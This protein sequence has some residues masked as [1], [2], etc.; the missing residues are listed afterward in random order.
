MSSLEWP[1]GSAPALPQLEVAY[2]EASLSSLLD[3]PRTLAVIGFGRRAPA[4]D[5]DPRYFNVGLEPLGAAVPFEVWRVDADALCG[6]DGNIAWARAGDLSFGS[7]CVDEARHGGITPAAEAAYRQL[8]DHLAS[9]PHPALLRSWNYIDAITEGEG[10]AERYRQFCIGRA[11]GIGQRLSAYPAATAIGLRDGARVLRLYW[12]AGPQPGTPIENPRQVAAWRYPRQYGPQPPSF[13]RATLPGAPSLPL[14][15]SGT[16]S[17]VGHASLHR[18]SLADQVDETFRNFASL[19]Q[20]ARGLRPSLAPAF[21]AGSLL[22]AYVRDADSAAAVAA[23]LDR[24]LPAATQRLLLAAD[25]CRAEL[26]IEIDGF[27]R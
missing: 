16:A 9:G 19:L 11:L 10:D 13:S 6:R 18:D 14:L 1:P 17:V 4:R 22:K 2:R 12:L 23:E 3:D 15:L 25:V 20:A 7:L 26:R 27:H 8:L 24:H 5:D 21:G